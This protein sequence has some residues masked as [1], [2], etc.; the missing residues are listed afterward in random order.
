M[1]G[2]PPPEYNAQG[3]RDAKDLDRVDP[4]SD[5]VR[6]MILGDSF[7]VGAGVAAAECVPA[8]LARRVGGSLTVSAIELKTGLSSCNVYRV[9]V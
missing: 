8:L 2:L 9:V 7:M 6:V 5:E 4:A 1:A 3:F